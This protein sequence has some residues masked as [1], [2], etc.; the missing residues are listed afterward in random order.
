M[1]QGIITIKKTSRQIKEA[2]LKNQDG[3]ARF[4]AIHLI[5]I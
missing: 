3:G 1:N 4:K 2:K 5:T